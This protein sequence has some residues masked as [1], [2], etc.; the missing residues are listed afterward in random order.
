M[1]G[2]KENGLF[3]GTRQDKKYDSTRYKTRRGDRKWESNDS[4]E[5]PDRERHQTSKKKASLQGGKR[6]D[7]IP[8]ASGR[9]VPSRT[10]RMSSL[11]CSQW[12][13][14]QSPLLRLDTEKLRQVPPTVE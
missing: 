6:E 3:T 1:E 2:S 14:K 11:L 8:S 5:I 9:L 12:R 7:Q 4:P 10:E 13:Q